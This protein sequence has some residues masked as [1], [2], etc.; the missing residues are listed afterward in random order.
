MSLG[1][2]LTAK[3]PLP[4]RPWTPRSLQRLS[5]VAGLVYAVIDEMD[6]HHVRLSVAP[7]P[8]VD[9]WG[10]L[11]FG[12]LTAVH[13]A[14]VRRRQLHTFLRHHRRPRSLAARPLRVG[15]AFAFKLKGSLADT[16]MVK[17]D[18][19]MGSP[20]YDI[21]AD[22]REAAKVSF[23]ASVAPTLQPTADAAIIA[24]AKRSPAGPGQTAR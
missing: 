21:T 2:P 4:G 18:R 9:R 6:Q 24:M 19:W 20:V 7:W 3:S 23:F 22:A 12:S 17:L 13:S 10:R 5:S 14:G 15:D 1:S 8:K 16:E 11:R